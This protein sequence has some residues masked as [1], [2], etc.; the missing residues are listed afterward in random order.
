MTTWVT[1]I[2]LATLF[3]GTEM[4]VGLAQAHQAPAADA[5]HGLTPPL[6]SPVG[7]QAAFGY[8]VSGHPDRIV[9]VD[10]TTR[11]LN[12]TRLETITINTGGKSVTWTFDTLDTR[13]FPL[14]RIVPRFDNVTVYVS[15][16]PL[17]RN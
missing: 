1:R 17:Y 10:Q 13:S 14:S 5:Q 11:Y 15:E 2:M 8:P 16:S 4:T 3:V 9:A 7:R 12:V 6:T